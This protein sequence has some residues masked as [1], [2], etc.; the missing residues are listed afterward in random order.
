MWGAV[1][2]SYQPESRLTAPV[3]VRLRGYPEVL[4]KDPDQFFFVSVGGG[5]NLE[6]PEVMSGGAPKQENVDFL[7]V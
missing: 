5:G 7:W 3:K 1:Y 2:I 6:A 4:R